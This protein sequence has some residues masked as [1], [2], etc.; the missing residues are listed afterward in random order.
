MENLV[1]GLKLNHF[2]YFAFLPF[3]IIFSNNSCSSVVSDIKEK[4]AM[5][6]HDCQNPEEIWQVMM[7][8]ALPWMHRQC[9]GYWYEK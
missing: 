6:S 7:S 2:L 4:G 5:K 8:N 9:N 3:D 1:Q